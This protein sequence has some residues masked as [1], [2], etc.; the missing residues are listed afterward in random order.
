MPPIPKLLHWIE[1]VDLDVNVKSW[2]CKPDEIA[3]VLGGTFTIGTPGANYLGLVNKSGGLVTYFF[4][5]TG[6]ALAATYILNPID[7]TTACEIPHFMTDS[8]G[9]WFTS[10]TQLN[11][12][13]ASGWKARVIIEVKKIDPDTGTVLA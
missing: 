3:H 8:R 1:I 13:S 11:G 2:R 7:V 6:S 10:K 5:A 4:Y 12:G 9:V